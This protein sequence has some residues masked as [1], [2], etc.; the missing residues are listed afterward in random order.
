MIAINMIAVFLWVKG[1]QII[2]KGYFKGFWDIGS[3]LFID[4][5]DGSKAL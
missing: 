1:V 5:N 4:Y 3:V 2:G